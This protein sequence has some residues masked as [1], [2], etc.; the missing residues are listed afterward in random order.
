MIAIDMPMPLVCDDCPML[1][2]NGD[3]PTCII[4]HTSRGYN[5]QVR[6]MRMPDCPIRELKEIDKGE[7]TCLIVC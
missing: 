2:D 3:Y 5:F 7:G 1:D 4:T 6:D